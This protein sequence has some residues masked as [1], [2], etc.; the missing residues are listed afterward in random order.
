MSVRVTTLQRLKAALRVDA[1]E[2]TGDASP[3]QEL[4]A[5]P[6]DQG[7]K[8]DPSLIDRLRDHLR[9]SSTRRDYQVGARVNGSVRLAYDLVERRYGATAKNI[10]TLGPMLFVLLAEGCLAKRQEKL[11]EVNTA[12]DRLESLATDDT[13]YFTKYLF[14][15]DAGAGVEESSIKQAD[16]RGEV[17]RRE[18]LTWGMFNE[19]DLFAVTPF[20]IYLEQLAAEI[21]KPDV[22]RFVDVDL[23]DFDYDALF[24][25]D[26]YQCCAGELEKIAGVSGRARLALLLGLVRIGEI[27]ADLMVES[28]TEQR[29]EWL[30]SKLDESRRQTR[31]DISAGGAK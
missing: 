9:R 8:I 28:A 2:L 29:V 3:V 1:S 27:P 17:V 18:G 25:A 30:E 7:V 20:A 15:V 14:D 16:I 6:D 26:P 13:L 4:H 19:D 10:V 31:E 23:D 24:G 22:I 11:A 21:D 12:K 5:P